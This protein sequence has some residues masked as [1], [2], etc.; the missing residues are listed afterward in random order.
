[1]RH[2]F[3]AD[4]AAPARS[5]FTRQVDKWTACRLLWLEPCKELAPYMRNQ[6]STHLARK[7]VKAGGAGESAVAGRGPDWIHLYIAL[8][9]SIPRLVGIVRCKS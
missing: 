4:T 1:M 6:P 3:R 2:L 7:R 8:A 5:T 9:A